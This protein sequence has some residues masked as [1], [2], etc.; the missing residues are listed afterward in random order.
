MVAFCV[1]L[2]GLV[3]IAGFQSNA[4][5]NSLQHPIQQSNSHDA[6]KAATSPVLPGFEPVG[7]VPPETLAE[8]EKFEEVKAK[9]EKGD[10]VAQFDLG[11][12]YYHG[13]GT[14]TNYEEAAKWVRKA[15]QQG[16]AKAQVG[17]ALLYDFGVGVPQDYTESAKWMRK[18]ADQATF[19]PKLHLAMTTRMASV[20]PKIFLR[21]SNGSAKR[22]NKESQLLNTISVCCITMEK[23]HRKTTWKRRNGFVER[24][25]KGLLQ[26]NTI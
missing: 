2:A 22:Q 14:T 1:L 12:R 4:Q 15:A 25:H 7:P 23:A 16:L 24:R 10:A 13:I 17:L 9:A 11:N 5:T 8:I 3:G 26:R 21:H 19:R 18:A 20:C 6:S